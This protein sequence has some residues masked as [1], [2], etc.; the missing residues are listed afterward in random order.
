MGW[1]AVVDER[2]LDLER[3]SAWRSAKIV[4]IA[5]E[6]RSKPRRRCSMSRRRRSAGGEKE[7]RLSG[8]TAWLRARNGPVLAGAELGGG[9]W[10]GGGVASR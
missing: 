3:M 9:S 4:C 2:P 10:L 1:T 7:G 5:A 8:G 6:D